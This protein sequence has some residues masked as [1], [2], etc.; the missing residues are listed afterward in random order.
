MEDQKDNFVDSNTMA[1]WVGEGKLLLPCTASVPEVFSKM[2]GSVDANVLGDNEV[3]IPIYMILEDI[4]VIKHIQNRMF[5]DVLI[6]YIVKDLDIVHMCSLINST[7]E[8]INI[9]KETVIKYLK[10]H[11]EN[12]GTD[13]YVWN[14]MANKT[15]YTYYQ[16]KK[17]N[18]PV[19]KQNNIDWQ[20][21]AKKI[22]LVEKVY[23][24]EAAKKNEH[25]FPKPQILKDD[26]NKKPNELEH[27]EVKVRDHIDLSDE[28]KCLHDQEEDIDMCSD[29]EEEDD[30]TDLLQLLNDKEKQVKR[31]EK[32]R[33]LQ[34]ESNYATYGIPDIKEIESRIG[35]TKKDAVNVFDAAIA[36]DRRDLAL[37]Y[38]CRLCVSRKYYHLVI[39]NVPFMERIKKLMS[40]N[41]RINKLIKYVMSY[42]FYMA[43]K[44]ER[45]LGRKITKNNRSIMD[46]DEFR[47]LPVFDGELEES[48]YFT[49]IYHNSKEKNLREQLP[50][51]L[52]GERKFTDKKEFNRRLNILTGNMLKDID[53]SDHNAFLTGSSLVTC[54]VTNPLEENTKHHDN[55]FATYLENYY[56][57]YDSFSSYRE[58]FEEAKRGVIDIFDESFKNQQSVKIIYTDIEDDDAFVV[59][60][61]NMSKDIKNMFTVK[62][63]EMVNMLVETYNE[64]LLIEK[65]IV[66]LDIAIVATSTE[67]YD[68]S[69]LA[70]FNKIRSNL[71]EG[72]EHNIYLYKQPIKYGFKWVLK[73][74]GAK[75]PIDF[76]KIWTP[77]HVLLHKFHLNIVRFWWDGKK[78]RALGSGVCAALTGVNQ[79]YRWFSNNKDPMDIVLKNMQRGYTTLLNPKEIEILKVYLS[80]VDK[81]KHLAGK[82]VIGKIH[83]NHTIFGHEG[84]IRYWFPEMLIVCDQYIDTS[85]YWENPIYV[86]KRLGCS[87]ETN[88]YG[89]IIAPKMFAFESIIRDLL[90]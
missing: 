31:D 59:C 80:E 72:P 25:K 55:P 35:F 21:I 11:I 87:L 3:N 65:K 26:N 60:V 20:N 32:L 75:R 12:V 69:V 6:G 68:K 45:L 46:E 70:I 38:A 78:V 8:Y 81:Y 15:E 34:L 5:V 54:V 27:K 73:G 74:Q 17:R 83:R 57:S 71:P 79:W 49:E 44:E 48:P 76:F 85:Q 56:P 24:G 58:K 4:T 88:S 84:G 23:P 53:L 18:W 77:A 14:Q 2:F 90:D 39:K 9:S 30:Y 40:E 13:T 22:G 47:A 66:D 33:K 52:Q 62:M 43:L 41:L 37:L 67:E 16:F 64:F 36:I 50:M 86:L 28:I 89:K 82:F 61:S 63:Q 51:H 10:T 42:S 29:L 19:K 1:F 7:Y